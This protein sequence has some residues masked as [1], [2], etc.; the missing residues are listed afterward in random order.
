MLVS[1]PANPIH[2][3][4]GFSISMMFF[5]ADAGARHASYRFRSLDKKREEEILTL[6][7]PTKRLIQP[8]ENSIL[9]SA[10]ASP[11]IFLSPTFGIV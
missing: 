11:F 3:R 1:T 9:T 5:E 6:R 8:F 4:S 7:S 10:K 2:L